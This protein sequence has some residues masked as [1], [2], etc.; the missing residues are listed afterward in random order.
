METRSYVWVCHQCK[1][2]NEASADMCASCGF[3]AVAS[4]KDIETATGE[5]SFRFTKLGASVLSLL[6]FIPIFF[7]LKASSSK[8]PW[9]VIVLV[10]VGGLGVF[11][12]L[13]KARK[14]VR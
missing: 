6:I 14:N 3:P 2:P 8:L 11:T 10:V 5:P 7:V 12:L 1:T 4:A 9:W 13:E